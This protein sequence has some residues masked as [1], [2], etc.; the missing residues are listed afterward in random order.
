MPMRKAYTFS[1][2]FLVVL[3]SSADAKILVSIPELESIAER[4][5]G[6]EVES[7]IPP[8]VDPHL[9][10]I[11]Y[12]ELSRLED[13]EI[14]LLANSKL[15]EF[16][17]KIK[18]SYAEKCLDFEDYNVT[19][20]EFAGIGENPHAYWLFPG[21]ALN[22]AF[23]LKER[24]AEI[25]P[26]MA[27]E[28]EKN[29]ESFKKAIELAEKDAEKIVSKVR[30]YSFVAMDPHTAYAISALGLKVSF[31]FPEEITPSAEEI[32]R[33]KQFENCV[34]VIADYQGGT[35]IGEMA[36]QIAKESKCGIAKVKVVSDL[37]YES[38]LISN[39]VALANPSFIE[40]EEDWI[41]YLLMLV[42]VAEAL[43]MVVIWQSRR[44]T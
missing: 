1:L 31:V 21:N 35:K 34:L 32:R 15:I 22:M 11:G 20:L 42:V 6:E 2:I 17:S 18:Q 36:K 16:E 39:A 27:E 40:S 5:S 23:A 38:L 24:L 33:I 44:R 29:Y 8:A 9:A 19:L 12:Q 13:A 43:A 26:E 30:D 37:S 41:L 25:H 14:V 3:F 10:S 4:I 28:F 7:L